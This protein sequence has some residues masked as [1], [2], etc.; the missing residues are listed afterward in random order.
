[1]H[2]RSCVID[3]SRLLKRCALAGRCG[4]C[5]R[6]L[7]SGGP[8][9]AEWSPAAKPPT[10][11]WQARP[12]F[13]SMTLYPDMPALSLCQTSLFAICASCSPV[14]REWQAQDRGRSLMRALAPWVADRTVGSRLHAAGEIQFAW[15]TLEI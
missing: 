12:Y 11:V 5:G 7:T 15:A 1:M 3:L 6:S 9:T 8:G 14:V 13:S 10:P 2:S 4:C